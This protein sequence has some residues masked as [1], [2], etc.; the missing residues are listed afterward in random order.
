MT[1]TIA[2]DARRTRSRTGRSRP[3][4]RRPQN[5]NNPAPLT[6][7]DVLVDVRGI[8][9][10][11]D[12]NGFVRTDGYLPGPDDVYV[13]SGLI[14]RYGLR[15]GDEIVGAVREG[16]TGNK[17]NPLVRLDSV[18]GADPE[19][20]R[21]RPEFYDLTPLFPQER[22]R[23][24]TDARNLTAR[25]IDL[26]MPIGKGQRA[27]IVA[28]PKAGK[29]MI[30]QNI[31]NAISRNN[32]EVHLMVVLVDERPEEVT[33]MQRSVQGEVIASTFDRHPSDH[34]AAAELAVGRA[35]RL[36]ERG[37]DVV[38]LLDNL[39]RLGR[40]YNNDA[41]NSGR[42]LSGGIDAA[43]LYPPKRILGA[44]RNVEN[45]GSLTII[46]AALVETGSTGDTVIFE[47]FKGTGNA[48]LKLDRRLAEKRVFP[49]IDLDSSGTRKEDI[50]LAPD[51]LVIIQKL[52]RV[53]ASRDSQGL[54]LLL[55][56]LRET[57]SNVEF[58]MQISGTTSL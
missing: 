4:G 47:E 7:D 11:R 23:L 58:L 36:V 19:S 55:Q 35:Q 51:E 18:N 9:D 33:D 57:R 52:R 50:L 41:S 26:V 46:A 37:Q 48:E 21:R 24:E 30:L 2:P 8:L 49:A 40:A 20:A 31:A 39:T 44:A 3:T 34:K 28:P 6:E 12:N 42:I 32:P 15:R 5:Q 25:V 10:I 16:E 29:T 43:A 22:L 45:G 53:L 27:L 54:E 14:K 1:A 17:A 56:K 13:S 38:I